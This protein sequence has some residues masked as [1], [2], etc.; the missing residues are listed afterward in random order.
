MLKCT[1]FLRGYKISVNARIYRVRNLPRKSRHF[2]EISP[3]FVKAV[4]SS[5][6]PVKSNDKVDFHVLFQY[7]PRSLSFTTNTFASTQLSLKLLFFSFLTRIRLVT[8]GWI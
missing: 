1:D 7:K 3:T 4:N 2:T 5:S 6:F 8:Q